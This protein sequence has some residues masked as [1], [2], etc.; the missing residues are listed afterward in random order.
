M[1]GTTEE[2]INE[3]IDWLQQTGGRIEDFAMEQAPLYCQEIIQW[4]FWSGII[5][6]L[7]GF[8]FFISAT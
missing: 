2:N 4:T 3:A 5:G 1:K 7:I 8:I 6:G